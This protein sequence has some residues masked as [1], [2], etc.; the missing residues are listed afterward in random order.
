MD[1]NSEPVPDSSSSGSSSPDSSSPDSSSPAVSP[2]EQ[3]ELEVLDQLESDL[4]A[5][6]QA[7]TTLEQISTDGSLGDSA[8]SLIAA[9]VPQE[10]FAST[11]STGQA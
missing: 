11:A 10:R 2:G 4:A 1:T 3:D 7:I 6:E 5:V 8:A 9:A